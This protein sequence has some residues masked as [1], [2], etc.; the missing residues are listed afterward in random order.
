MKHR[1]QKIFFVANK[2]HNVA[3]VMTSGGHSFY[4]ETEIRF[5]QVQ[6]RFALNP[7]VELIRQK[8]SKVE[9]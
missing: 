5:A 6:H 1:F 7:I 9:D 4:N 2:I 3:V 8:N